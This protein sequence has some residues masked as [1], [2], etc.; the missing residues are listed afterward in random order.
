MATSKEEFPLTQK[1][2]SLIRAHYENDEP[3]V[4]EICDELARYYD[5]IWK[6]QVA[7]FIRAQY[8]AEP[9]WVPMGEEAH[10]G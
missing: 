5:Q 10:N 3:R 2:V 8:G 4:R 1:V 6:G 9:V 7:S